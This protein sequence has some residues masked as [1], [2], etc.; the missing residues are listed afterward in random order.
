MM[1]SFIVVAKPL[2]SFWGEFFYRHVDRELSISASSI[3][4]VLETT[5]TWQDLRERFQDATP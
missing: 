2:A 1:R 4:V 3:V 5:G